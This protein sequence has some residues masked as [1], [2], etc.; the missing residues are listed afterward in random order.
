MLNEFCT[1]VYIIFMQRLSLST[2]AANIKNIVM[3]NLLK[4]LWFP[5]IFWIFLIIMHFNIAN[6]FQPAKF[7][8]IIAL[9]N[10]LSLM[11]MYYI[12]VWYLFPRFFRNHKYYF[13]ISLATILAISLI[14]FFVDITFMPSWKESQ[15]DRPPEIF[16]YFRYF[17]SMGF[18]FF[19]GTSISLMEQTTVLKEKEKLLTKENLETELKLLKAQINPHFIFNALNNIYSLT[20]LKSNN[21]PDSVLMLSDMLRYVF[22][23][24]S[25]DRVLLSA[26]IKYIENFNAFQQMKSEY[27]QDIRLQVDTNGGDPEIAPMLFIPIIE[28]AFKYSRIEEIE[29]AHVDISIKSIDNILYFKIMNTIPET[30]KSSPGSGMGI[31]NVK[32]RLEIIYPEKH[33]MNIKDETSEFTVDLTIEL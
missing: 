18:T 19:V 31:K 3:N 14:F 25:K 27:T 8:L 4:K 16:H 28:N 13:L 11:L 17:M 30:T 24:C 21:A 20:Y 5:I 33:Q 23:D 26:E 9:Y 32:H 2:F 12:T 15:G 10:T 29:D 6:Y 1:L 7:A 22:Y